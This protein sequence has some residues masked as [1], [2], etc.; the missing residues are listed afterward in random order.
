[1]TYL[2]LDIGNAR[3]GVAKSDPDHKFALPLT[4]LNVATWV[5]NSTNL[6]LLNICDD[7][8]LISQII[9]IVCVHNAS[10]LIIGLPISLEGKEYLNSQII[11]EFSDI[12][13][14]QYSEVKYIETN[15]DSKPI[16]SLDV[17]LFDERFTT[18]EAHNQ[19][20]EIGKS[21]SRSRNVVDQLA[22]VNILNSFLLSN[23][24]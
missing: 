4:T 22:A 15:Q 17:I 16:H 11:R 1:M 13:K 19:L 14:E 18:I 5:K 12:I 24:V 9:K 2:C 3:V 7:S 6:E 21:P 23:K 10:K 8:E 20:K